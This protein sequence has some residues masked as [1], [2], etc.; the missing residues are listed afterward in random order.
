M[1]ARIFFMDGT[2]TLM[3]IPLDLY[4]VFLQPILRVLIPQTQSLHLDRNSTLGGPLEGISPDYQHGFMNV[5]VT[6]LECSI[7]CH[8][9][10]ARAVFE[11]IIQSLPPQKAKTIS[12]CTEPYI[13]LSVISTELDAANRVLELTSP[14]AAAGIPIFFITSF[15]SDFI[16]APARE[17]PNVIDALNERGFE[18]FD[19]KASFFGSRKNS[20]S[21]PQQRQMQLRLL[22]ASRRK[23]PPPFSNEYLQSGT[24]DLLRKRGITPYVAPDLEV[25]ACSARDAAAF[26]DAYA[27]IT[28]VVGREIY[29]AAI[30][31]ENWIERVE[32][33]FYLAIVSLL[34]SQP[35]FASVT[36]ARDDPPSLLLDKNLLHL[37]GNSAVGDMDAILIPIFLDLVSLPTEVTGIVCVVSGRLV[38]ELKMKATSELSYLSTARAGVVMLPKQQAIKA[39][40]IL[41]PLMEPQVQELD[42]KEKGWRRK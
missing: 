15:Y 27:R 7:V 6:H 23:T 34:L 1:S 11:P 13:V 22:G 32:T 8:T 40:E 4:G 18:L 42:R 3:R 30:D 25:I 2:Y 38:Q 9:S 39:L 28:C 10:W 26:V 29:P 41:R 20:L 5:S 12:S 31:R 14:L 33:K 16:V 19:D 17:R 21:N 37:F 24:F 36:L 35:R